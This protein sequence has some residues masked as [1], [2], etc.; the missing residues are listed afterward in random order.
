MKGFFLDN[1]FSKLSENDF[2]NVVQKYIDTLV[3]II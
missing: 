1:G 3:Q 2:R